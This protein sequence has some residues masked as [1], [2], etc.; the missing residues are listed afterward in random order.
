VLSSPI[1]ERV[2]SSVFS[3][4]VNCNRFVEN[5]HFQLAVPDSRE[6]ST[7]Y[8]S[9]TVQENDKDVYRQMRYKMHKCRYW[10]VLLFRWHVKCRQRCWCS[11]GFAYDPADYI[12]TL[13]PVNPDSFY[14]SDTG[15]PG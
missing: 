10:W 1:N 8:G 4:F 2:N 3:N 14:L 11:C 7:A 15:S 5:D 9:T 13:A 12:T 6:R